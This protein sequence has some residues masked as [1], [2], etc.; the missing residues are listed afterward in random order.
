VNAGI[1]E[2]CRINATLATSLV[3]DLDL[4]S[5]ILQEPDLEAREARHV[6]LAHRVIGRQGLLVGR[7][8]LGTCVRHRQPGGCL[9]GPGSLDGNQ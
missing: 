8:G 6:M 3:G 5:K 7:Y 1:C 2:A 4:V 9:G